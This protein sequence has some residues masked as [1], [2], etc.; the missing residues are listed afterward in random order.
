MPGWKRHD[1]AVGHTTETSQ[2][3]SLA[4]ASISNSVPSHASYI[5]INAEA[6][7]SGDEID[8]VYCRVLVIK[9]ARSSLSPAPAYAI[10]RLAVF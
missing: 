2:S 1:L 4:S 10:A 9:D 6:R 5:E 3:F 8:F 7:A